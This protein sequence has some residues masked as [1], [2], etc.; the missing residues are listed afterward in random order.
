MEQNLS[1]WH[2][3]DKQT[4]KDR[5]SRKI[6]FERNYSKK[7][8]FLSTRVGEMGWDDYEERLAG[9]AAIQSLM[10]MAG[11]HGSIFSVKEPWPWQCG[12]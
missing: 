2:S 5:T 11:P 7:K 3:Q 12:T 10:V 6:Q 8:E 9:C 1:L 4:L